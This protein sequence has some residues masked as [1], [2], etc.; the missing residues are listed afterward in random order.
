MTVTSTSPADTISLETWCGQLEMTVTCSSPAD[1][2]SLET[3]L[4][5]ISQASSQC[6]ASPQQVSQTQLESALKNVQEALNPNDELLLELDNILKNK[7]EQV[8]R[9]IH[10]LISQELQRSYQNVA[11]QVRS[12]KA[13][14]E[15]FVALE[16]S[17]DMQN[18]REMVQQLKDSDLRALER[19]ASNIDSFANDMVQCI[20]ERDFGSL[21]Q[22]AR[23][24]ENSSNRFI[25]K[26]S[27]LSSLLRQLAE[28]SEELQKVFCE[29]KEKSYALAAETADRRDRWFS[30]FKGIG[31]A[32]GALSVGVLV[33]SV[34]TC[35]V[36]IMAMNAAHVKA[37]LVESAATTA[38]GKSTAAQ[39]AAQAAHVPIWKSLL[40]GS[41]AGAGAGGATFAAAS[42]AHIF[43]VPA[44]VGVGAAVATIVSSKDIL[45]SKAAYAAASAKASAAAKAAAVTAA[46]ATSASQTAA[47]TASSGA[48]TVAVFQPIAITSGVV[49]A[50]FLLG[51]AGRDTLKSVL[52][53]LWKKEIE[54]HLQTADAFKAIEQHI[55]EVAAQLQSTESSNT[56]LLQA[57]DLVRETAQEMAER[58]E[59]AEQV[60]PP[61]GLQAE[62]TLERHVAELTALVD[63]LREQTVLLLPAVIEMQ[64]NLETNCLKALPGILPLSDSVVSHDL[65]SDGEALPESA[66]Q[67]NEPPTQ[68]TLVPIAIYTPDASAPDDVPADTSNSTDPPELVPIIIYTPDASA[69][70]EAP[71]DTSSSTDAPE[72]LIMYRPPSDGDSVVMPVASASDVNTVTDFVT[73]SPLA[74]LGALLADT[75]LESESDSTVVAAVTSANENQNW[76][77]LSGG[78]G[79]Q[80]SFR[81]EVSEVVPDSY[82]ESENSD[83]DSSWICLSL[84][85]SSAA[86]SACSSDL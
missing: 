46:A 14:L 56:K 16:T 45:A 28:H 65:S 80:P 85:V 74:E 63:T 79:S 37:K 59:D 25:D 11:D 61:A 64:N 24:L 82:A 23:C 22:I 51:C 12:F 2:I 33:A 86:G 67:L 42:W 55:C 40:Q 35:I 8:R 52:A 7:P 77:V 43:A 69:P 47:V 83:R 38:V 31:L 26:Y 73:P 39:Q 29:G 78:E 1:A 27:K 76:E 15:K 10:S 19:E 6:L 53:K 9:T 20:Q 44:A 66:T 81:T 84:P 41:A 36:T 68:Q 72:Q 54:L 30:L 75:A 71:A 17:E 70:E 62:R 49:V 21:K 57:L 48:A 58:A 18:L 50:L 32:T 3:A 34:H 5:H 4:I 13:G 60:S